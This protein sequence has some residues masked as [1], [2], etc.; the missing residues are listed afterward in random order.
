MGAWKKKAMERE[1]E[2]YL[3]TR[4]LHEPIICNTCGGLGY[5]TDS[6]G[7]EIECPDCLGYGYYFEDEIG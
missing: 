6:I 2:E 5:G 7:R 1:E 4:P 3:N